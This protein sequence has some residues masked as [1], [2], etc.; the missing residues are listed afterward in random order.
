MSGA[1]LFSLSYNRELNRF[2]FFASALLFWF[3][4]WRHLSIGSFVAALVVITFI[5]LDHQIIPDIISLPGII[6]GFAGSFFYPMVVL[7]RFFVGDSSWW[8]DLVRRRLAL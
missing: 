8:G 1:Y 4:A 5:D 6:V 2:S 7:G 3:L